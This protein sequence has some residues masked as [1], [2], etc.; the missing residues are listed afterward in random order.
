MDLL[1]LNARNAS[2]RNMGSFMYFSKTDL[3]IR[4]LRK[5]IISSWLLRIIIIFKWKTFWNC[6]VHINHVERKFYFL[7]LREFNNRRYRWSMFAAAVVPVNGNMKRNPESHD[8]FPK[9]YLPYQ[10]FV[11]KH[12]GL[13]WWNKLAQIVSNTVGKFFLTGESNKVEHILNQI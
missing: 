13:T 10:L 4:S 8:L 6:V 12:F 2:H 1:Q 9:S 11:I 5:T 7:V 3:I